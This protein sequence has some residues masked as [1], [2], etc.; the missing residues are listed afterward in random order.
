MGPEARKRIV[1]VEDDPLIRSLYD[2]LLAKQYDLTQTF[3]GDSGLDAIRKTLPDL[4]IVDVSMPKMHGFELCQR[5][6]AEEAI[7]ATKILFVSG[8]S[9]ATDIKT[10]KEIGANDYIVK[11]FQPEDLRGK[12]RSLL[13]A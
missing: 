9:Y 6:R 11:P 2:A 5:I 13:G 10:A 1:V 3:D 7:K 12:I 8:K 4:A